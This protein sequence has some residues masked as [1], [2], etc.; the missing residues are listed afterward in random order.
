MVNY[1]SFEREMFGDYYS[2]IGYVTKK[3]AKWFGRDSC[4]K[5]KQ[6]EAKFNDK[7]VY[8][9]AWSM[10]CSLFSSVVIVTAKLH[11]QE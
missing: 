3:L 1:I 8:K 5:L 10:F 7:I 4:V 11:V 9:I 6:I 2:F